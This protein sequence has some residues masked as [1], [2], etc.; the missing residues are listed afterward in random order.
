V[1]GWF[2][3]CP[4]Q[5]LCCQ[6]DGHRSGQF[7][8]CSTELS[9]SHWNQVHL[10]QQKWHCYMCSDSSIEEMCHTQC[11]GLNS[12][13]HYF[14][15]EL[16]PQWQRSERRWDQTHSRYIYQATET[17]FGE[18]STHCPTRCY[19]LITPISRDSSRFVAHS[20]CVGVCVR[21]CIDWLIDWLIDIFICRLP[22]YRYKSIEITRKG[23]W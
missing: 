3:R 7:G 2:S 1:R 17:G 10:L 6:S 5:V 20:A 18:V 15:F 23:G 12:S 11:A 4:L 19:F 9:R 14:A 21:G 8:L 22:E 16:Q 13:Q